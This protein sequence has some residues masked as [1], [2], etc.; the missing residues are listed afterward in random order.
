[1]VQRSSTAVV[2]S[3][4]VLDVALGGLYQEGGVR[5]TL[6]PQSLNILTLHR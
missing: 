2:S 4:T 6:P 1:M 3:K 5:A